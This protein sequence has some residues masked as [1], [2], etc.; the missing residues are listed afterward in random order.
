[1]DNGLE[2]RSTRAVCGVQPPTRQYYHHHIRLLYWAGKLILPFSDQFWFRYLFS[3]LMPT[4][5]SLLKSTQGEAI[6][7]YYH[8]NHLSQDMLVPLYMVGEALEFVH[9]EMEELCNAFT[10]ELFAM[11]SSLKL[12]LAT[13]RY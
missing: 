8:E 9:R 11:K 10:S 13:M 7:N 1:M 3:W 12:I 5:M 2:P 6:R 4:K